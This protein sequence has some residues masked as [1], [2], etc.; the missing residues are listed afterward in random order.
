MDDEGNSQLIF[1]DSSGTSCKNAFSS[2]E[3]NP[4]PYESGAVLSY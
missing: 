4:Q 3:S 1:Q 2:W